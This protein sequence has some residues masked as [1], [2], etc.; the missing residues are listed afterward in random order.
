[1]AYLLAFVLRIW[2]KQQ[3]DDK[4][5]ILITWGINMSGLIYLG[6]KLTDLKPNL[7]NENSVILQLH[8]GYF[9]SLNCLRT[10]TLNFLS[11]SKYVACKND[12]CKITK[13][14]CQKFLTSEIKNSYNIE[15]LRKLHSLQIRIKN[16][17]L[18][19]QMLRDEITA[20]CALCKNY[21][22]ETTTVRPEPEKAPNI[23][24]APQLLTMNS[25]NKM[26]QVLC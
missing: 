5:V 18:D 19:V 22:E 12:E 17:S 8:G 7:F 1:M 21:T 26:L 11:K 24:Y 10:E 14:I 6:N 4:D 2:Q 25:L 3:Q 15:K 9:S 16:K 20:R 23:R 13:Y